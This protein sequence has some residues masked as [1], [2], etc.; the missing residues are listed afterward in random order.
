MGM[1]QVTLYPFC[2]HIKTVGIYGCSSPLGYSH[3]LVMSS[4]N[5]ILYTIYVQPQIIDTYI[6][7]NTV[8][9]NLQIVPY[10]DLY[11]LYSH[12]K[13]IPYI[14]HY[15]YTTN[16]YLQVLIHSHSHG[17]ISLRTPP[18]RP[19]RTSDAIPGE[20]TLQ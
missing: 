16:W 2:D 8:L 15:R 13:Q 11:K 19:G 12:R 3:R 1:S 5:T 6:T 7:T 17:Q 10:I 20:V 14:I 9:E 4:Y 18:G